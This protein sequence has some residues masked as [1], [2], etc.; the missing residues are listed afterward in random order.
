[1]FKQLF[2][3][4]ELTLDDLCETRSVQKGA[5]Y[6]DFDYDRPAP[7]EHVMTFVG[8]TGRF[9]PVLNDGAQLLRINEDRQF[10]VT[11]TKGYFW[12]EAEKY[13][14]DMSYFE[15]LL[16]EAVRTIEKFVP[17]EEFIA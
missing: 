3:H 13:E 5:M 10:A 7:L 9:I 8:R 2:S 17:Y 6:L 4:E 1:V 14:I 11:A 12:I 16:D 15:K